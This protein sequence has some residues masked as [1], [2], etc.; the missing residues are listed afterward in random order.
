MFS[1]TLRPN[2]NVQSVSVPASTCGSSGA[3]TS[4][5][6]LTSCSGDRS[7]AHASRA[8]HTEPWCVTRSTPCIS[9]H[10]PRVGLRAIP[11]TLPSSTCERVSTTRRTHR[12]DATNPRPDVLR[13]RGSHAGSIAVSSRGHASHR[14]GGST[15]GDHVPPFRVFRLSPPPPDA[16]ESTSHSY[17]VNEVLNA[18]YESTAFVLA[19]TR[20]IS[21]STGV[22]PGPSSS[23]GMYASLTP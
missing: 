14:T 17:G 13:H 23:A 11:A 10:V 5:S 7:L 12:R 4:T 3:R 8:S 20:P 15:S 16:T 21:T 19:S 22:S 6:R 1:S 18:V 2:R 9:E